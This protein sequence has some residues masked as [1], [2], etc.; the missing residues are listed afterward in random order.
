MSVLRNDRQ[1][2]GAFLFCLRTRLAFQFGSLYRRMDILVRPATTGATADGQ[3][4]PSYGTIAKKSARF[5]FAY[6]PGSPS[7]LD[8]CFVGRTFLSVP[9]RQ[10][11]QRTDKN[12]RP[13]ERSPKNRHVFVLLTHPAR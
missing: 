1:K 3:E 5:C 8:H 12:V 7:S 2:I 13:T 10:V 4:C 9:R 11:Q 6:A